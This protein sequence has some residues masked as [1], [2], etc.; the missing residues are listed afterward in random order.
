MP[1]VRD[2]VEE[3]MMKGQHT[4]ALCGDGLVLSFDCGGDDMTIHCVKAH[5]TVR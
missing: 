3:G 2:G 1:G 5:G 4:G